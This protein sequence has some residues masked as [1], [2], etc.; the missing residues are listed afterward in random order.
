MMP[1]DGCCGSGGESWQKGALQVCS[2]GNRQRW[3]RA[4]GRVSGRGGSG[5][6]KE[7]KEGF[8]VTEGQ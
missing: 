3:L 1:S 2:R 4:S 6:A 8:L 5:P 7:S